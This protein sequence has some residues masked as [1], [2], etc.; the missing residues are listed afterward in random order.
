MSPHFWAENSHRFPSD[1]SQTGSMPTQTCLVSGDPVSARNALPLAALRPAIAALIRLDFPD[2][3]ADAMVSSRSLALYRARYVEQ[4]IEAERGEVSELQKEVIDAVSRHETLAQHP[5]ETDEDHPPTFGQRLSDH[6]ASFGGS[7]KFLITFAAVMGLWL[8]ANSISQR[9]FDPFPFILL[10]LVLSCL[11][12]VQAPVIMMSQNRKEQRDRLRAEHD[13]QIN[14][15]AELEIRHLHE[16][17]DHLMV[18]QW[19]RLAA[20]Q[21]TQMEMITGYNAMPRK[22]EP[23]SPV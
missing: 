16:K 12:A 4:M 15:K 20:I 11:A 19:E 18:G 21:Q 10:N 1:S 8:L 2:A 23:P 6:L 9:P 3:A 22:V 5:H 14:L 7:W 13:Y 17:I